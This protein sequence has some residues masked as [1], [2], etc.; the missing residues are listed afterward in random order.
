MQG[1]EVGEAGVELGWWDGGG[2][3]GECKSDVDE[4]SDGDEALTYYEERL[5]AA[6]LRR[7]R[8][9]SHKSSQQIMILST[10]SPKSKVVI[11]IPEFKI[12]DKGSRGG[13]HRLCTP[14][15]DHKIVQFKERRNTSESRSNG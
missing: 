6:G 10:I 4:V 2:R 13:L 15:V 7:L 9:S 3:G 11:Y 14:T 12:N 5:E 1:G 8:I